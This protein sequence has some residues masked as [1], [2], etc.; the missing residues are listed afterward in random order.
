MIKKNIIWDFGVVLINL[1]FE[2]F[3]ENLK[4]IG[5][6]DP[7]SLLHH[8]V[9][10]EYEKGLLSTDAFFSSIKKEC[11]QWVMKRDIQNAWNSILLDIPEV[12]MKKL[13]KLNA[14]GYHQVMLSNTNEEHIRC[15]WAQLGLYQGKQFS[16]IFA[17]TY[18][19]HDLKMRKPEPEIYQHVLQDQNWKA[20]ET[21]FVDDNEANIRAA[22]KLGITCHHYKKGESLNVLDK[23]LSIPH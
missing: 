17:H 10:I 20:E 6:Q 7:E 19:S 3:L 11:P 9:A 22:E 12:K 13:K 23:V 4:K 14:L 2:A 5:L 1:H 16:K 21:L 18:F 15:I 8:P